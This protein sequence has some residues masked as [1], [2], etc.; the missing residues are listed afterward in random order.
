MDDPGAQVTTLREDIA[1]LHHTLARL[2]A[3]RRS[4]PPTQ[5]AALLA[6]VKQLAARAAV[7]EARL[8]DTDPL[9]PSPVADTMLDQTEEKLLE[10][11]G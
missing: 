4:V 3:D 11:S 1:A 5:L 9:R 10:E 2:M 7:L 6:A 8:R